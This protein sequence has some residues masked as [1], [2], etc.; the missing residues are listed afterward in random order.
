MEGGEFVVSEPVVMGVGVDM[1]CQ[2]TSRVG[3]GSRHLEL[4]GGGR[5]V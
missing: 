3:I 5:D 1:G 4:G 2:C